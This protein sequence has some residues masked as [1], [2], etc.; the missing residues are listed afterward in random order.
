MKNLKIQLSLTIILI[1]ANFVT[2][3][4]TP[5]SCLYCN[6]DGGNKYCTSCGNGKLL[7]GE[8]PN[9]K[10]EGD[11]EIPYC[12]EAHP[13]NRDI[14][15]T[16]RRGYYL[17]KN[18]K[19]KKL[20]IFKCMSGQEVNNTVKCSLC[21]GRN[22]GLKY[23]S[24]DSDTTDLPKNCLSGNILGK[25]CL[26]CQPGYYPETY[27]R[28]CKKNQLDGCGIYDEKLNC[29]ECDTFHGYYAVNSVYRNGRVFQTACKFFGGK[30]QITILVL[31][32]VVFARLT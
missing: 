7:V 4:C 5:D 20:H 23:D 8:G 14:C 1:L 10:C 30:Y 32:L 18:W 3:E 21:D 16:C 29:L 9:R 12:W 6:N 26:L 2:P 22:L 31:I 11:I 17:T 28:K 27:S 25:G 24:C 13:T 15:L 19:C